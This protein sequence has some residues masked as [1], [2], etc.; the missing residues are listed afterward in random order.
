MVGHFTRGEEANDEETQKKGDK[1]SC[2]PSKEQLEAYK[3]LVKTFEGKAGNDKTPKKLNSHYKK[4][5]LAGCGDVS[6]CPQQ[7]NAT[8]G[9][10]GLVALFL[11]DVAE[12]KQCFIDEFLKVSGQSGDDSADDLPGLAEFKHPEALELEKTSRECFQ[13]GFQLIQ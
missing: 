9:G 6:S 12:L 1:T 3:T 4:T 11:S 10:A 5:M 2:Q 7:C 13:F 8:D